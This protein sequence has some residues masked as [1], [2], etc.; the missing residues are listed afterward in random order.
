MTSIENILLQYQ[1]KN[2][3]E[4][5]KPTVKLLNDH[6]HSIWS[7]NAEQI[8]K[9]MKAVNLTKLDDPRKVNSIL[10][11]LNIEKSYKAIIKHNLSKENNIETFL[12][13][14]FPEKVHD[15]YNLGALLSDQSLMNQSGK[16]SFF[17]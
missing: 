15:L 17:Y 9:D 5:E 3:M 6:G 4:N 8:V 1:D 14:T 7:I 11:N 2:E 12:K 10:P 13:S 16:E